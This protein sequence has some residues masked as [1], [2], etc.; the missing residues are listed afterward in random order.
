MKILELFSGTES[1][2][3]VAKAR[4]HEVFTVDINSEFNPDLCKDILK[5]E[6]EDIPFKPDIIWASPPCQSFSVATIG[7]NWNYDHTPKT[8]SAQL[9]IDLVCKTLELIVYFMPKYYFIE[10][11]RGK[12][13]KMPFM[14]DKNRKTIS[15]CQYGDNRMKPTDIW[16]NNEDWKPR[17]ICKPK[18]GCHIAA[19]RGSHTGTQGLKNAVERSIIP[20]ELCLEI[21]KSC[22]AQK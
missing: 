3:K 10:N 16:T 9:S 13:R 11:P 20:E 14:S 5:L 7:K 4:G 19:P 22:E 8:D 1:F 18:S 21:I 17:P 12:L 6:P 2:S 15:Y